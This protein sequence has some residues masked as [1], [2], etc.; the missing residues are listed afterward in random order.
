MIAPM[1]TLA[2]GDVEPNDDPNNAESITKGTYSGTLSPT[3]QKD[4]YSTPVKE[5]EELKIE[6]NAVGGEVVLV[7]FG[8][9]S[10]SLGMQ[11]NSGTSFSVTYISTKDDTLLITIYP[12][13]SSEESNITYTLSISDKNA[14][15]SSSSGSSS[16]CSSAILVSIPIIL[17][18]AIRAKD[19]HF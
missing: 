6:I 14:G 18:V 7:A 15:S 13:P 2:M 19:R 9:N 10:G 17:G 4:V 1:A 8:K 11:T 3:D 16:T 12:K 5:S